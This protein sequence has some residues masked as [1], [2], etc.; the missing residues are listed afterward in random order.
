MYSV[1]MRKIWHFH[2]I[3]V[4]FNYQF[5]SLITDDAHRIIVKL[6]KILSRLS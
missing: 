2:S 3:R 1:S 4:I 6:Q 5:T